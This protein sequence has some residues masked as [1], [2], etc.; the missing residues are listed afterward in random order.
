MNVH[1]KQ[2]ICRNNNLVGGAV[3]LRYI[4]SN[5]NISQEYYI[6]LSLT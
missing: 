4:K 5:N 6:N 2:Y 1:Y 3:H